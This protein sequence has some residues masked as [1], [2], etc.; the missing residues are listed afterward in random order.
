M[1][2]ANAELLDVEQQKREA[3]NLASQAQSYFNFLLNRDCCSASSLRAADRT[4]ERA[5]AALEQLWS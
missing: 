5:N 3:A 1:L 4:S 2:R